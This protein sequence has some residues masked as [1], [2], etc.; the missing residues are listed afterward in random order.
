MNI[1]VIYD[2]VYGNT[3]KIAL[4]IGGELGSPEDVAIMRVSEVKPDQFRGLKLLVV[5]SPTQRFRPTLAISNL[6][7]GIST[8]S[9]KGVKV[10]AFDTRLT[11]SNIE[12]TPILA[13]FVR[14]FGQA[15]YAAKSIA[16]GL[17]SKG[18]ELS[19]PSEGFFVEGMEGPLV[20]GELERAA[21]WAKQI[22]AT[23]H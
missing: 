23:I 17:K 11:K 22:R 18:G 12:E 21:V 5:G 19:A 16:D 15:A 20:K 13:F 9:L 8:N 4:A 6:L 14:L 3:E 7:K 10:T 2:S 1:L